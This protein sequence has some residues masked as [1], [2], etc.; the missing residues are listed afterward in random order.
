[1]Y[2]FR[3][4]DPHFLPHAGCEIDFAILPGKIVT[5]VGENGIGKSTLAGRFWKSGVLNTTF[6]E[7]R[8]LDVFYDRPLFKIKNILLKSRDSEISQDFFLSLWERF[9]LSRKE[10]RMH[11]TLSGGEGQ[12]LKLCLGLA[13]KAQ[14]IVL[15]EPSQFLD[16]SSK[17]VLNEVM[18]ELLS[19]GKSI[20]LIE[21]DYDWLKVPNTFLELG[22]VDGTLKE[23]K[24]WT[25]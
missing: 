15:D 19:Q 23:V 20:L 25:T 5:L 2:N 12:A 22:V 17:Q 10:T 8:P 6:I 9:Q 16:Q 24:S 7:Q 14:C 13:Q 18:N 1:M 4:K 11:S 3:L 21:H